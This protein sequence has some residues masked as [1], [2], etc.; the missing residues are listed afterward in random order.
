MEVT[1]PTTELHDYKGLFWDDVS[2]Q[3]Y[4]WGELQTLMQE[5]ANKGETMERTQT[6]I[7]FEQAQHAYKCYYYDIYQM[8][9]VEYP[10]IL[11][12]YNDKNGGWFLRSKRQERLAHVLKSG[13]VKLNY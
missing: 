8:S 4:R 13:H 6:P 7:S 12:S 10:D 9:D 5:R 11:S 1:D 3:L 2:K